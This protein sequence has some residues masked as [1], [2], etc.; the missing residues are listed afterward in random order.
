MD[1]G[2]RDGGRF[3]ASGNNNTGVLING[4]AWVEGKHGSALSFD[5]ADDYVNCGA[6]SSLNITNSMTASAWIYPK[7]L[8]K[9]VRATIISR[10][11]TAAGVFM[12]LYRLTS[13]KL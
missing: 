7:T 8:A 10:G 11:G 5:G 3:D 1:E 4:P 6:D 13:L 12:S 9:A 2:G